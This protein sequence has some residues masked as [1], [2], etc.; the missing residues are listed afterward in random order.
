MLRNND[1]KSRADVHLSPLDFSGMG[2]G[3]INKN[4]QTVHGHEE[5]GP[6]LIALGGR[7]VGWNLLLH[8]GMFY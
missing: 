4:L 3:T 6:S 5:C 8:T 7:V 2:V 1:W